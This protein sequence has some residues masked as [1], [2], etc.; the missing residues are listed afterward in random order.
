MEKRNVYIYDGSFDGFLSVVFEVWKTKSLLIDIKA[1][2]NWSPGFFDNDIY[3]NTDRERASRVLHWME[4]KLPSG[5]AERI[6]DYFASEDD[7]CERRIYLYLQACHRLGRWVDSFLT[8]E[9][10]MDFLKAEKHFN[11]EFHRMCGFARFTVMDG[12]VMFAE[13]VTD[14]NQ[15]IRLVRFFLDRMPGQRFMIYDD[16][17]QKAVICDGFRWGTVDGIKAESIRE[18]KFSDNFDMLWKGYLKALTIEERKNYKLQ[19]Q[20]VPLKYRKNMTEFQ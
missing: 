2:E 4:E 12:N 10:V 6:Y 16:K 5:T 1:E 11:N 7:G 8:D 9:A 17:R 20:L 18:K 3:I 13:I 14:F 15:L 19:Q